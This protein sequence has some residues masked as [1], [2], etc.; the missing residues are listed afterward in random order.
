[1]PRLPLSSYGNTSHERLLGHNPAVLARWLEL[2]AEFFSSPTF[3]ATF[4]EQVRRA[5][6]FGNKCEYCMA[7]AGPPDRVDEATRLGL[8]TAFADAISRDHRSITEG[9]IAEL[10]TVFADAE[11]AEFLAFASFITASQMFGAL[12]GLQAS[13]LASRPGVS[14]TGHPPART[15]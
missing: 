5:L 14:S 11:V 8:A 13:D 15:N 6:A 9:Q 10:R 7:K 3:D 1:M 12:L 4:R 2:E